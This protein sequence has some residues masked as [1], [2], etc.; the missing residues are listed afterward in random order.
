[1]TPTE[2]LKHEHQIVL[3]VLEGAERRAQSL[4]EG[5][6]IDADVVSE[7]EEIVDFLRDFVDRCHHGKEETHYFERM[8][9]RGMARE[10]GPIA[11]MLYEHEQ[12][13]ALVRA[14][15]AATAELKAGKESARAVAAGALHQF[16]ELL[17]GHI[18]KEDNIL[19]PMADRLFT[20]ED[21]RVLAEA[22]NRVEREEMGAGVHEKYHEFAH[23]L[24]G[25]AR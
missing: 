20:P 10:S 22:F 7:L 15:A 1:M 6:P 18:F 2:T 3:L 14:L 4:R 12:G 11:V 13:R 9:E 16:V 5:G 21:V 25:R 23:R 8:V 17:R 19:Y 24:A